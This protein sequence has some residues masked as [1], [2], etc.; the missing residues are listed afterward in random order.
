M[1]RPTFYIV[2]YLVL[3]FVSGVLVGGFGVGLYSRRWSAERLSPDEM[4][5]RYEEEM[6][7]RLNLNA[8]QAEKLHA[9]L[10]ATRIR[11]HEL[12]EKYRPEV[13]AIQQSQVDS[14]NTI[15]DAKQ[16][17]EY[18]KLREERERQHPPPRK[19][20]PGR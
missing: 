15:L 8:E 6:R 13:Q 4:R 1:S 16:Q 5:K 3:V 2:L 18:T 12:R 20:K 10:E 7:S 17:A 9:I 14:I 19:P 11:F